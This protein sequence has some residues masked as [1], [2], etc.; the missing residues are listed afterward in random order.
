MIMSK[1]IVAA[2]IPLSFLHYWICSSSYFFLLN[3]FWE[4]IGTRARAERLGMET[5][6]IFRNNCQGSHSATF[7]N[8]H[9]NLF[10]GTK[11]A[12]TVI[13]VKLPTKIWENNKTEIYILSGERF[14]EDNLLN[15]PDQLKKSLRFKS[16]GLRYALNL[17]KKNFSQTSFG[18]ND[19]KYYLDIWSGCSTK[20]SIWG[21]KI[22]FRHGHI[23]CC[24]SLTIFHLA[25]DFQLEE[26]D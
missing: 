24:N 13:H 21:L 5:M 9:L 10:I 1:I 19:A 18:W 12:K 3:M 4:R 26:N 22:S 17:S 11:N 6:I 7:L 23:A 16:P 14:L 8:I 2:E 15:P 20:L 25:N